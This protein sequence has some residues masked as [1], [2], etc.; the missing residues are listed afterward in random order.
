M[1]RLA[2]FLVWVP[3][4]CG[5]KSEENREPSAALAKAKTQL[6]RARSE[7]VDA[8]QSLSEARAKLDELTE[9]GHALRGS[10][11]SG[12]HPPLPP[13]DAA[14]RCDTEEHCAIDRPFFDLVMAS[15]LSLLEQVRIV[16]WQKNGEMYGLKLFGIDEGS[17]P[18]ALGLTKGDIIVT[19][20]GQALTSI[21][22]VMTL[23]SKLGRTSRYEL[24]LERA[25][26]RF[27]LVIEID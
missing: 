10:D 9:M 15:P 27:T 25:D 22:D 26:R 21:N 2:W 19:I 24:V 17:I 23:G 20:G 5:G 18:D 16:P 12:E 11:G 13:A 1:R 3:L 14:I 8:K 7:L 6:A 4:A